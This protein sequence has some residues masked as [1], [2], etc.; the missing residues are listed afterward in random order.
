LASG[1]NG[2]AYLVFDPSEGARLGVCIDNRSTDEVR[3]GGMAEL[4][5]A[6]HRGEDAPDLLLAGSTTLSQAI[7]DLYAWERQ[8]LVRVTDGRPVRLT[9]GPEW[10]G[11]ELIGDASY[12]CVE[13]A[14]GVSDIIQVAVRWSGT[15]P[16]MWSRTVYRVQGA[17]AIV[18]RRDN[19]TT[20]Q[21]QVGASKSLLSGECSVTTMGG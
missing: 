5:V 21:R 6:L 13:G 11:D 16:G 18:V 3:I 8:R 10:R 20:P 1:I 15:G 4:L 14:N 9:M 12:G 19:G 17:E 2:R 7:G